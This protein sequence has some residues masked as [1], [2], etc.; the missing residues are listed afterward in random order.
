MMNAMGTLGQFGGPLSALAQ[1]KQATGYV[2]QIIKRSP[3]VDN[4]DTK[5]A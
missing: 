5:G 1:A 2:L 3:L 4:M